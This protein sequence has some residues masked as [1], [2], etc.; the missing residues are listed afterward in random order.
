MV[1][2]VWSLQMEIYTTVNGLMVKRKVKVPLRKK[3]VIDMKGNGRT[4]TG[5]VREKNFYLINHVMKVHLLKTKNKV[6]DL[7]SGR[8]AHSMKESLL[9]IS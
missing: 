8:M 7:S 3:M 2:D 1:S 6:K 4:I 5:R 9:M